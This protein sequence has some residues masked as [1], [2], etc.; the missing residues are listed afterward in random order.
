[1]S[2]QVLFRRGFPK[3]RQ[4]EFGIDIAVLVDE[5]AEVFRLQVRPDV[6]AL[7]ARSEGLRTINPLL[8]SKLEESHASRFK[9]APADSATRFE[10]S[11]NDRRRVTLRTV[12][13]V[14]GVDLAS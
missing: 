14:H 1:M 10:V 3:G 7:K 13:G 6:S 5:R 4:L 11:G 2:D 9:P 8:P 12:V